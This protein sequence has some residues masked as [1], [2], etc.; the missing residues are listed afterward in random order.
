MNS[1]GTERRS[2][3]GTGLG[4][5]VPLLVVVLLGAAVVANGCAALLALASY[6]AAA[7]TIKSVIDRLDPDDP[8]Y[9]LSGY[10]YI[11]RAADKIAVQADATLPDGGNWTPYAD[12]SVTV[13]TAPP[14]ST[15]TNEAGFFEFTGLPVT[16]ATHILTIL[17]PED[18]KV[19]FTVRLDKPSIEPLSSR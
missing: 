16:E 5:R 6:A 7:S 3:V 15:T 19:Q 17:T 9:S 13:D 12:A 10:V 2:G 11:D 14:R 8:S 18:G 1:N 4:R